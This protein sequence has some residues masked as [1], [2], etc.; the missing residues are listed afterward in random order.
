MRWITPK[1]IRTAA[2]R[3]IRT[4]QASSEKRGLDSFC[5]C[6]FVLGIV[7][8]LQERIVAPLRVRKSARSVNASGVPNADLGRRPLQKRGKPR[9]GWA[10]PAPTKARHE[11]GVKP[12]LHLGDACIGIAF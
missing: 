7:F 6:E 12:S 3:A 5:V 1:R 11:G 9:A 10:S 8:L 2:A 4:A